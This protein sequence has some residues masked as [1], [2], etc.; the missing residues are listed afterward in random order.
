MVELFR[1]ELEAMKNK[2]EN[3]NDEIMDTT[4]PLV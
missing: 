2:I 1:Q 3:S 4:R